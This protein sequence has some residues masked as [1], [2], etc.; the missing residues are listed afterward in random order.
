M[1]RLAAPRLANGAQTAVRRAAIKGGA[2]V[3]VA[4]LGR[5]EYAIT[6][7]V[8]LRRG[9]SRCIEYTSVRLDSCTANRCFP[10]TESV[11]YT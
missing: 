9:V 10:I 2:V 7:H 4:T 11:S 6:T 1:R 3:A 8:D 5:R